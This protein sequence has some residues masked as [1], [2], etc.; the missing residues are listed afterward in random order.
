MK[1][2]SQRHAQNW[3][4]KISL[5][6]ALLRMSRIKKMSAMLLFYWKLRILEI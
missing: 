5:V 1:N 4:A 2:W 6:G 3:P